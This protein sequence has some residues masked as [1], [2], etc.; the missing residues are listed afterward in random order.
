MKF[1]ISSRQGVLWLE[2]FPIP[3]ISFTVSVIKVTVHVCFVYL[4]TPMLCSFFGEQ[5]IQWENLL[6]MEPINLLTVI[7]LAF[8]G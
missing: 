4:F 5:D 8:Y 6:S 1:D 7:F 2:T 3:S